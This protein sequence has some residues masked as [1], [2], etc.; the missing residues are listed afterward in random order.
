MRPAGGFLL[1][2]LSNARSAF[3][4]FFRNVWKALACPYR[5]VYNEA[6]CEVESD[7]SSVRGWGVVTGRKAGR[8]YD[9]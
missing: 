2:Q 9:V 4:A 7:A 5:H 1:I 6:S 3:Y 8:A